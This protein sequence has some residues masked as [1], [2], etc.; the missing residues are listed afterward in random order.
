MEFDSSTNPL[1]YKVIEPSLRFHK[2]TGI[3]N[4]SA[5]KFN[6]ANNWKT[7]MHN[8]EF[9]LEDESPE[10]PSKT[11]R[12]RTKLFTAAVNQKHITFRS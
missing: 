10:M 1:V 9:L 2:T 7:K 6:V 11:F 3:F 4:N 5:L 8:I 12:I